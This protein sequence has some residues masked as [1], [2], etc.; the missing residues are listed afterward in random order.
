MYLS[1]FLE[2]LFKTIRALPH[3]LKGIRTG[4]DLAELGR[5]EEGE[6]KGIK[7]LPGDMRYLLL[8]LFTL[9]G[10]CKVVHGNIPPAGYE[11]KK[12]PSEKTAQHPDDRK[13][14]H[15]HKEEQQ[16]GGSVF[17]KPERFALSLLLP[18]FLRR[19][20][21]GFHDHSPF[22]LLLMACISQALQR[23]E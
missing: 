22:A 19:F 3:P 15:L 2:E 8:C 14:N 5:F 7:T 17:G 12:K 21:F 23:S 9:K 16:G 18:M 20:G 1:G 11:S 6:D 10:M 13:R 4:K